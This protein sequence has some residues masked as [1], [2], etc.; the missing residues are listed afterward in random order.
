MLS[1]MFSQ[2]GLAFVD[3]LIARGA[4]LF[5]SY[6]KKQISL[7]ELRTKLL[8]VVMESI[9]E[10]ELTHANVLSQT[11]SSFMGAMQTSKL[12]QQVWATAV[13][14]ELFVLLWHQFFIPLVVL[15]VRAT[16]DARWQYPSSGTTVEWAYLLVAALMGLG[17]VVLRSGPGAGSITDRLKAMI[18]K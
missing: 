6:M 15:I 13:L 16:I 17:P 11:W 7:E 3:K 1:A 2:L 9:K 5:E 12:M 4:S 18:G 10:I 14:S 8:E